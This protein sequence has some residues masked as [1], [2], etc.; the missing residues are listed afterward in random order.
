MKGPGETGRGEVRLMV[1]ERAAGAGG[2]HGGGSGWPN[3][4]AAKGSQGMLWERERGHGVGTRRAG[5]HG[6]RRQLAE[7]GA[8]ARGGLGQRPWDYGYVSLYPLTC[9]REGHSSPGPPKS[10]VF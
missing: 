2:T 8:G 1:E 4:G 3:Q 5:G 10:C 9:P 7:P 6:G